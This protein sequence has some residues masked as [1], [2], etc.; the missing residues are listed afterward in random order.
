MFF[1]TTDTYNN[2]YV[3]SSINADID[4]ISTHFAPLALSTS[5]GF[6]KSSFQNHRFVC[7]HDQKRISKCMLFHENYDNCFLIIKPRLEFVLTYDFESFLIFLRDYSLS[8]LD[9][10]LDSVTIVLSDISQET[11]FLAQMPSIS[12]IKW[13][14]TL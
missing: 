3:E 13:T 4:S 11:N 1:V 10:R 12:G 8:Y 5:P 2:S 7:W 6:N 14:T 9:D